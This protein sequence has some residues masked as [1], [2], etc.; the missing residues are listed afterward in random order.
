MKY[1]HLNLSD[2]RPYWHCELLGGERERAVNNLWINE[3]SI[4]ILSPYQGETKKDAEIVEC[5]LLYTRNQA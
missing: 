1:R 2:N 5:P 4:V 3:C